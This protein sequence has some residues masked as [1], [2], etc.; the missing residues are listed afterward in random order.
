MKITGIV[1]EYNP[2]HNGHL[3]H[4]EKTRENG[5]THIVAVMSGNYVQ[6]GET[7]VINKFERANLAI[8]N[9]VDLVIEIPTVFSLASAEFYAKGAVYLLDSLGC[10]DEISF[11]S[12]VGSVSEIENAAEIAWECQQSP[13]L[14]ELL[15]N[16][17]SYPN[18]INS[19]ILSKYGRKKGNRV[20]DILA[21]PNNVLAVE[22]LKAIK[23]F[24][25]E[26]KP[27]TT[28]RKSAAHDSMHPLDNIA[29]ASFIRKCMEDG[30]DFYGLVPDMVYESYKNALESGNIANIKNLERILIYK[31]R[32]ITAD[33]LREI[34]D[35]GQG[36]E[37]R[38]L[39]CTALCS[40]EEIMQAIKSK[41]YTMARIRRIIYNMLIGITKKDLE[42]L[43]PYARVLAVNE[44]GRDILSKAKQTATIPV[45]TSL[46]KLAATSDDAKRFAQLEARASDIY[47][48]AQD[49]IGKGQSDYKAMIKL[50]TWEDEEPLEKPEE[51]VQ[52]ECTL[53]IILS[54]ECE[55]K[56]EV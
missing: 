22:Y 50:E 40:I 39:D 51:S 17:M 28:L 11:G 55:S 16:G 29:S 52:P 4:I 24:G 21:S 33:E 6:R 27:F 8:K 1:S 15:K 9:G 25:S 18:A 13:E 38:I 48:L 5:A 7:A 41:R 53:P 12:E 36:L 37:N 44:R 10:V 45:N 49:S 31:L 54:D 20:G 30:N 32:T 35:V 3:Y 46:A 23:F 42:I 47:A 56:N 34:P 26:I 43:P 2:L 19:M 14:E